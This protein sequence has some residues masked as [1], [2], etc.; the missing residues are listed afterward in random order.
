MHFQCHSDASLACWALFSTLLQVHCSFTFPSQLFLCSIFLLL[1][2]GPKRDDVQEDRGGNFSRSIHLY[3]RSSVP[4]PERHEEPQ[5]VI[6]SLRRASEGLIGPRETRLGYRGAWIASKGRGNRQVV[7]R[8]K[9]KEKC[10]QIKSFDCP[11]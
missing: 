10:R 7:E 5:R 6:E 1:V 8:Y 11:K 9:K 3:I 4:L 2:S